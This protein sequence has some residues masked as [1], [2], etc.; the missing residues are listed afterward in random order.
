M[1]VSLNIYKNG[2]L[3]ETILA[4]RNFHRFALKMQQFLINGIR[5]SFKVSW[6]NHY[7]IL[8]CLSK[9]MMKLLELFGC[10][11]L[12]DTDIET[13]T[14]IISLDN[15]TDSSS[16]SEEEF[17]ENDQM[18]QLVK[19]SKRDRKYYINTYEKDNISTYYN[20]YN[21]NYIHTYYNN[22]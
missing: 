22:Y 8:S 3:S 10:A 2:I 17:D 20:Y 5:S 9:W 14:P 1:S 15:I 7:N 13:S 4:I 18:R 6:Q 12:N 16:V 21:Y 11:D 19:Y